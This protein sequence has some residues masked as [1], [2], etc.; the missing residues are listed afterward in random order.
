M[1]PSPPLTGV[2]APSTGLAGPDPDRPV[3][4]HHED[5]AVADLAGPGAFGERFHRRADELLRDRDLEP[6]L[7]GE[8]HLHGRSAVRLDP[9]ELAAMAL[10]AAHRDPAHVGPIERFEHLVG[11]FGTDDS[12]HQFHS[13]LPPEVSGRTASAGWVST[14][15]SSAGRREPIGGAG[16]G[17]R[18]RRGVGWT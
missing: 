7:L 2:T 1:T 6:H 17:R 18:R 16:G 10:D 15:R 13:L 14:A 3:E 4:R 12:D 9:V 8:P 5:L 11:P